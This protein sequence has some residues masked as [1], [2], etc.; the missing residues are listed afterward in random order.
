M[1][2]T[3]GKEGSISA[4]GNVVGELRSFELTETANEVDTSTMGS[5]WTGVDSTQK[6]WKVSATMFW[7]AADTGQTALAVGDKVAVLLYPAGSTTGLTERSGTALVASVGTAQSHDGIIE[8]TIEMTG[9][10]ALTNDT[11]A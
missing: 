6:S 8:R 5:D 3:K 7:D 1:A 4:G 11:V 2:T 9:D 10:G